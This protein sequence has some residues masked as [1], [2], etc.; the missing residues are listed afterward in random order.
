VSTVK[1]TTNAD[2]VARQ[3]RAYTNQLS[4]KYSKALERIAEL[5]GGTA[6]V[7]FAN[8]LYAGDNDVTVDVKRVSA[9]KYQV[10]ASGKTVLFIE[11]GTGVAYP[12]LVEPS[13]LTYIHGTYGKLKGLN[14]KGWVYVGE[15]GN[16]GKPVGKN[17]EAV[18]TTGN[19][20]ARAMY[21]ASKDMRAEI[22]RVFREEF[23]YK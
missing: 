21:D 8:A 9:T 17:G 1:I 3:I 6:R 11:F 16:I 2:K 10:I 14:P 13:G 12:E 19:P 20:P 18:H 4:S 15:P 7:K 23:Q 5:G 22:T